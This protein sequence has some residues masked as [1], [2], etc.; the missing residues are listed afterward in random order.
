MKRSGSRAGWAV[1]IPAIVLGTWVV[2]TS[3]IARRGHGDLRA[4]GA[5]RAFGC[6]LSRGQS[7]SPRRPAIV[8]GVGMVANCRA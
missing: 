4:G 8:G 6:G 2:G 7:A 3:L 1:V 5:A